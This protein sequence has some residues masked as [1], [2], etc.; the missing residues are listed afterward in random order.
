MDSVNDVLVGCVK[1]LG[2]SKPVGARLWPELMADKAQRKLLDCLNPEREHRLSPEQA[3]V[4]MRWAR[5][6]GYHTGWEVY[7]DMCGYHGGSAKTQADEQS[8]L[9]RRFVAAVDQVNALAEKLKGV[10]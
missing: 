3:M 9:Q 1:A 2:G 7:A 5:D 10:L 6:I 8:E 4:I